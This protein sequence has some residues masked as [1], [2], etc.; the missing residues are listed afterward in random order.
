M[1]ALRGF[2]FGG[3]EGIAMGLKTVQ[4]SYTDP[5]VR[6]SLFRVLRGNVLCSIATVTR[7]G[8][9]HIN[10]A[11]FAYSPDL[12][13]YFLSDRNSLHC[14]NLAMNP[15]MA[16]TVFRSTQTWGKP[17]RGVQLFGSAHEARG[18]EAEAAERAYAR[19][20]PPYGRILAGT[21]GVDRSQARQL[22]S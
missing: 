19:R 11:Y 22:R 5:R 12:D 16:M 10:T 1:S 15:S 6:M 9:A 2:K 17:D 20:F 7:R 13:L 21:S 3:S 4:R 18:S 8:R 14:R